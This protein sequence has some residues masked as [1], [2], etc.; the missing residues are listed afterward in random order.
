MK[1]KLDKNFGTR[2]QHLFQDAGYDV[3]TIL[4]K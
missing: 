1:L 4:S 2:T 3:Q